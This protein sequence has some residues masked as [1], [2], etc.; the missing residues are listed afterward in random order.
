VKCEHRWDLARPSQPM[1]E[2]LAAASIVER[3][4]LCG[5]RRRLR[6]SDWL[7]SEIEAA[8]QDRMLSR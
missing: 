2:V 6:L 7:F 5:E 4:A 8:R 1:R 3:C